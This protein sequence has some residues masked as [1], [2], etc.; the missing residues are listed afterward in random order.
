MKQKLSVS[1]THGRPGYLLIEGLVSLVIGVFAI[2]TIMTMIAYAGNRQNQN[3]INFHS[4]LNLLESDRYRFEV[5]RCQSFKCVLYS[6]V[7]SKTYRIEQYQ[8]MIRLTGA[9]QGHVPSLIN[10]QHVYWTKS[11][12][13]LRTDVTFDNGQKCSAYSKLAFKD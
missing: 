8:D 11:R 12:G 1:N 4:Y 7:T 10:V 5:R 6:P 3:V 2:W 13:C 9:Y